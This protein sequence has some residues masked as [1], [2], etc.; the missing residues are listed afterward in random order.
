MRL[1]WKKFRIARH[2]SRVGE[3]DVVVV[4][5]VGWGSLVGWGMAFW[6]SAGMQELG[7]VVR[8]A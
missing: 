2:R 6:C 3:R 4:V 8:L 1:I 5:V 7:E